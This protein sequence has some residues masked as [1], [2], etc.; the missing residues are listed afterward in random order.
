MNTSGKTELFYYSVKSG[1][2]IWI[3]WHPRLLTTFSSSPSH[4][5]TYTH[6][7]THTSAHTRYTS[8]HMYVHTWERQSYIHTP[9][10]NIHTGT[11]TET[12]TYVHTS[13]PLTCIGSGEGTG[14]H[15]QMSLSSLCH[16]CYDLECPGKNS[17]IDTK[18]KN[19]NK[20]ISSSWHPIARRKYVVQG[21]AGNTLQSALSSED[22]YQSREVASQR[23][24]L[25]KRVSIETLPTT[26]KSKSS[27]H[28][29]WISWECCWTQVPNPQL[30]TWHFG[31]SE[32]GIC[33]S[34]AS[35]QT[36]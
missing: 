33:W 19:K 15:I 11:H 27:S 13:K 24:W 9:H 26:V 2:H 34:T 22:C 23:P 29:E 31:F 18:I 20:Q 32:R 10:T 25:H 36:L 12:H 21:T 6:T 7:Y 35:S 17:P 28:S 5:H 8:T 1:I 30:C 14:A 16:G 3:F 4:K